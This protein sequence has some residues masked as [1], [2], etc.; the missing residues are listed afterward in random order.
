M[1]V[2]IVEY[3]LF[4]AAAHKWSS[5]ISQEGYATLEAA[6]QYIE[7]KPNNLTQIA[8]MLYE[9]D[10]DGEFYHIHDILIAEQREADILTSGRL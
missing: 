7:R 9:T 10:K 3:R 1:R 8:P 2:Y 4:N 5:K 6:Q